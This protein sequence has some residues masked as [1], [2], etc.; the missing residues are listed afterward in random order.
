M[1]HSII[2]EIRDKP[3]LLSIEKVCTKAHKNVDPTNQLT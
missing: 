2:S 3:K 1:H